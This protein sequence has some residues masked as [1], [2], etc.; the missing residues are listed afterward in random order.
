M[1][2]VWDGST[3]SFISSCIFVDKDINQLVNNTYKGFKV[4]KKCKRISHPLPLFTCILFYRIGCR[5]L[6]LFSCIPED[7]FGTG[8]PT[9]SA[10]FF[11]WACKLMQLPLYP[12]PTC[13][14]NRLIQN[15]CCKQ[16]IQNNPSPTFSGSLTNI[17]N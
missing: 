7:E 17:H 13:S 14:Y 16:R 2:K 4:N 10:R 5:L 9:V 8:V 15:S 6:Y 1:I 12:Q 3:F 11:D